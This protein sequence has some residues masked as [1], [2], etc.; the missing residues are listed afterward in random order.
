M[1]NIYF[2]TLYCELQIHFNRKDQIIVRYI[3]H[4]YIIFN[5]NMLF[6]MYN[7]IL[8]YIIYIIFNN[9]YK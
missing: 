6:I 2:N 8:Y 7:I 9:N 4:I 3:I 1:L 5:Y